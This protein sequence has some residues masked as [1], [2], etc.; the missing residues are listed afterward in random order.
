MRIDLD[1]YRR[2]P[3]LPGELTARKA[4]YVKKFRL[5]EGQA[6][7][8]TLTMLEQLDKCAT[9]ACRRLLLGVSL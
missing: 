2:K 6:K 9:D 7:H 8:L 1:D 4:A 3:V 5:T